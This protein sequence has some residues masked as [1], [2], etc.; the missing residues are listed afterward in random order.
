MEM[1]TEKPLVS[2]LIPAFNHEKYIAST[3]ESVLCQEYENIE[4]IICDDGSSDNT[5]KIAEEWV[6]KNCNKFK[7]CKFLIQ[8]NKGICFT[9]NRLVRASSGAY[10]KPMASDD[11]LID[12]ALTILT[13]KVIQSEKKILVFSNI[14]EFQGDEIERAPAFERIRGYNS[15][16]LSNHKALLNFELA[17]A[18]GRPFNNQFYSRS[19]YDAVGGYPETLFHED[20]YFGF[21]GLVLGCIA[22]EYR[23][24]LLYRTRDNNVSPG[25]SDAQY[26]E[27]SEAEALLDKMYIKSKRT[28]WWKVV[29]L[30]SSSKI[31]RKTF[32]MLR[33]LIRLTLKTR[34]AT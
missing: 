31:A 1:N 16:F 9:L 33:Q 3:L 28:A 26:Y 22:Y 14:L 34:T 13:E 32:R 18:W 20:Y 2:V 7:V 11:L 8:E 12:N 30:N 4:L 17:I 24:T 10:I 6:K 15:K 27:K 25:L 21:A 5:P 23:P 29:K 19:F